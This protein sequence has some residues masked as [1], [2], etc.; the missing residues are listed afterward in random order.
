MPRSSCRV[1]KRKGRVSLVEN[2][3]PVLG[4]N[5]SVKIGSLGL[6]SGDTLSE[7]ERQFEQATALSAES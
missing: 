2:V 5:Y 3:N 4:V 7:A 6:W 1:L